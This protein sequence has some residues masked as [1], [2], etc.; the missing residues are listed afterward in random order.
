MRPCEADFTRKAERL[1][2]FVLALTCKANHDIGGNR[3]IVKVASN[4]LNQIAIKFGVVVTVHA[5]K[6]LVTARLKRKVKLRTEFGLIFETRHHFVGENVGLKRTETYP[7]YS[8]D[9]TN[10]VNRVTEGCFNIVAVRRKVDSDQ[11]DFLMPHFCNGR[12]LTFYIL[13]RL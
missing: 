2:E 12:N 10:Y 13:E 5:F 8:V 6:R 7:F 11:D 4:T 3:R 1:L 9:G